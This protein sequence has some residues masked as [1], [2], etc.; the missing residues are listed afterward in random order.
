MNTDFSIELVLKAIVKKNISEIKKGEK[1]ISKFLILFNNE[2]QESDYSKESAE[3][4]TWA[5]Y[6][7]VISLYASGNNSSVIIEIYS[8]LEKFSIRDL[9]K[10]LS[11]NKISQ[12]IIRDL[13]DRKNLSDI[14]I[15]Y[16]KLGIWSKSDLRFV[17]KLSKIRNGIAHKNE[18]LISNTLNSGNETHHLDIDSIVSKFDTCD[19]IITSIKLFL[20]L[21]NYGKSE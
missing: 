15:Y 2:F 12:S 11:K 16:E 19:L 13:I 3:V 21:S 1:R 9:P 6:Q 17:E 7:S 20:K 4:I 8:I 5:L 18:K 14:A 10:V